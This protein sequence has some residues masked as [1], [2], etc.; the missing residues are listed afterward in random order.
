MF[1]GFLNLLSIP[2][3]RCSFLPFSDS[4]RCFVSQKVHKSETKEKFA[5]TMPDKKSI[6]GKPFSVRFFLNE[7]LKPI[8]GRRK[9]KKYPVYAQV[10]FDNSNVKV[11]VHYPLNMDG[12]LLPSSPKQ[13]YL[14]SNKFK[15]I[16]ELYAKIISS[17]IE[18]PSTSYLVED[19]SDYGTGLILKKI[20]DDIESVIRLGISL[21]SFSLK[22]LGAKLLK[23]REPLSSLL[24]NNAQKRYAQ[25]F[26]KVT[27]VSN[28]NGKAEHS[29]FMGPVFYANLPIVRFFDDT[30]IRFDYSKT[31]PKDIQRDIELFFYIFGADCGN[32]SLVDWATSKEPL[33]LLETFLSSP[34][35]YSDNILK[36]DLE[37]I[38]CRYIS[39]APPAK[40][41]SF[42]L[43]RVKYFVA[44]FTGKIME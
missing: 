27:E 32:I 16:I 17:E 10:N 43:E 35:L 2:L 26:N 18:S 30:R 36:V 4:L 1:W 9:H 37:N 8:I 38:F 28:R 19:N 25:Y 41:P 31:V 34:S 33:L 39:L 5:K 24:Q 11:P 14:D 22:G 3:T 44:F 6:A 12:F 29:V 42:Y 7:R 20:R 15:S 23:Y 21:G 40:E 13:I